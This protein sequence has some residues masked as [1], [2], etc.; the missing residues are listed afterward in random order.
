M[1]PPRDA[2]HLGPRQGSSSPA[3]I[4]ATGSINVLMEKVRETA[5]VSQ[6]NI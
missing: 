4:M 6:P 5:P 3:T 2:T 1:M